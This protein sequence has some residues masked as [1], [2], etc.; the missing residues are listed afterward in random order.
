MNKLAYSIHILE[1]DKVAV[2][3]GGLWKCIGFFYLLSHVLLGVSLDFFEKAPNG[4]EVLYSYLFDNSKYLIFIL[5]LNLFGVVL[6]L[7]AG[8][9]RVFDFHFLNK[10]GFHLN[11]INLPLFACK[12]DQNS[13]SLYI[14]EQSFLASQQP[15]FQY[16]PQILL[17]LLNSIQY[18]N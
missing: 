1:N 7:D 15:I 6:E 3:I 10:Y 18:C 14:V 16:Q 5:D 8:K 13:L 4:M 2:E 17:Q 11:G 9:N 12:M